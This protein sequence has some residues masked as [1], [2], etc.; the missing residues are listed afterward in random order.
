MANSMEE[1]IEDTECNGQSVRN[2]FN[3]HYMTSLKPFAQS[4]KPFEQNLANQFNK[5]IKI[6]EKEKKNELTKSNQFRFHL[7]RAK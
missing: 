1:I 2:R 4:N 3:P 7:L 6:F 5:K